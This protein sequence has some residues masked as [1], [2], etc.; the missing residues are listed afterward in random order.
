MDGV[1]ARVL[2][3][4]GCDVRECEISILFCDDQSMRH[5]N[6]QYRD[7]DSPTDVLAF[8]Q[9]EPGAADAVQHRTFG[10]IVV[11]LETAGRRTGSNREQYACEVAL[12]VIHG[13]LHLLGHDHEAK[14]EARRMRR[15]ER[16][17]LAAFRDAMGSD[18]RG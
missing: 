2:E 11:S 8:P 15:L 6:K 17:Y 7:V 9:D 4:N 14:N 3:E 5:L 16:K 10:D 18:G 12:L 13:L 1:I